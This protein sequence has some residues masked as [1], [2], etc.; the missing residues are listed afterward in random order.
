VA[1][2]CAMDGPAF[3]QGHLSG[4]RKNFCFSEPLDAAW[5]FLTFFWLIPP[6][7]EE[8]RAALEA[9]RTDI[10]DFYAELLQTNQTCPFV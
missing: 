8:G 7:P 6:S 5:P 4:E 9:K 3:Q 2:F 1:F 10:W